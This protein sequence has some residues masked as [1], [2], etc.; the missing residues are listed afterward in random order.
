MIGGSKR[1]SVTIITGNERTSERCA[2]RSLVV[3]YLEYASRDGPGQEITLVPCYQLPACI[4]RCF[5]DC[6]APREDLSDMC[7]SV[8]MLTGECGV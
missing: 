4:D 8:E 6:R 5:A 2:L 1:V 3:L 7:V